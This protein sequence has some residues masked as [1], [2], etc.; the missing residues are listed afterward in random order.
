MKKKQLSEAKRTVI[1]KVAMVMAVFGIIY[2][3]CTA[4]GGE[5]KDFIK[6]AA[7]WI[8]MGI[9]AAGVITFSNLSKEEKNTKTKK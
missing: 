8:F 5:Y 9:L 2:S 1:M 4:M 7:P 6:E 3:I